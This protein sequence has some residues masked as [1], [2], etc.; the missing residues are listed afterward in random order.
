MVVV[1]YVLPTIRTLITRELI[2]KHE[3][4]RSEV[5]RKMGVTPAAVTQYLEGVRGG[6]AMDVAKSSEKVAKMVSKTADGLAKDELSV[7]DVVG[8]LCEICRAM[9]SS[10][11]ICEMHK[12]VQPGLEG[13]EECKRLARFCP[14]RCD[15]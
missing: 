3:L 2:E 1:S 10:G 13:G 7:Y 15:L 12:E 8:N 6:I 14:L 11:S 4:K 5:A 9:R